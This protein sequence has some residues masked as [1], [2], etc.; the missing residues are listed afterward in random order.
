[1]ARVSADAL[2]Q[3]ELSPALSSALAAGTPAVPDCDAVQRR[4]AGVRAGQRRTVLPLADGAVPRRPRRA[5]RP[6]A[7]LS[8]YPRPPVRLVPAAGRAART[9]RLRAPVFPSLPA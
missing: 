4:R 9:R 2:R 6:A 7:A 5:R 3:L 1:A 8:A